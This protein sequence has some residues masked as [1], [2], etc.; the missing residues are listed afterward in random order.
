M[1]TFSLRVAG[2]PS[3]PLV[4]GSRVVTVR[5]LVNLLLQMV[6]GRY[7]GG[8]TVTA[9]DAP[10][11]ATGTVAF[12]GLPTADETLTVCNTVFTAKASA[13][14][15]VQFTIGA[16]ATAAGANLAAKINAHPTVSQY[17]TASAATGTV[18]LTAAVPGVIGNALQ[19]SEALSNATVTA[20]SGG[21]ETAITYTF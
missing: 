7:K 13:S 20:F 3:S 16:D 15:S 11:A 1:A 2:V 14:T 8:V 4:S 6:T 5:R 21:T 12:T 17:V 9:K 10:V 19:L 18:T